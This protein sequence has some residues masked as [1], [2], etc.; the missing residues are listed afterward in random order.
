AGRDPAQLT[1]TN[2]LAI[3]VGDNRAA[4]DE[5]LRDWLSTEWDTAGWSESTIEHGI[6]GS[7]DECVEQLLAHVR[8][9][10]NRLVLIPYR[11]KPE[12]VE[13]LATEV[14]PRLAQAV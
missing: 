13:R 6:G 5:P 9:G 11:Y 4:V 7:P 3:C 1:A 14:L 8:T 12:Q 10:V 2:Q